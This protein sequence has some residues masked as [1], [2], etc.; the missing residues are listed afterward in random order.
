[1]VCVVGGVKAVEVWSDDACA[2]G[3][4]ELELWTL[5]NPFRAREPERVSEVYV[6]SLV[7]GNC[8]E[9]PA[10]MFISV[11]ARKSACS[12]RYPLQAWSLRSEES[13]D[14]GMIGYAVGYEPGDAAGNVVSNPLWVRVDRVGGGWRIAAV[15]TFY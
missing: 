10:T 11:E 6:R 15:D 7:K 1:M 2:C 8:E 13:S 5:W 3:A 14:G 9:L 12:L 4:P